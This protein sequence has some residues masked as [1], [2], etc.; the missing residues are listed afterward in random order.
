MTLKGLSD[1]GKFN[2]FSSLEDYPRQRIC[3]FSFHKNLTV[4]YARVATEFAIKTGRTQQH[5]NSFKE[6]FIKAQKL[7]IKSV[8]NQYVDIEALFRDQGPSRCSLFTRDPRDLVVSGYHYHKRGA[9]PWCRVK[10]PRLNTLETVNM[11]LPSRF[12]KENESISE[13]LSR[14]DLRAGLQMEIEMRAPHYDTLR[15]WINHQDDLGILLTMKYDEIVKDSASCFDKLAHHYGFSNRERLLW[16]NLAEKY[17]YKNVS[18]KHVRDP[19]P[20]QWR[21]TLS[22]S[23]IHYF[24]DNYPDVISY[25]E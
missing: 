8:N 23:H 25:F 16:L 22:E 2:M 5:F 9:E 15:A 21:K 1:A 11:C 3:H 4:Y 12:L 19:S 10:N 14:L 18:T 17:S 13:C 7:D 20:G 6:R 24:E